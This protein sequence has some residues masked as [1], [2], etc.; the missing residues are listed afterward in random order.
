M[1]SIFFRN[2]DQA[3]FP[4]VA[5]AILL[6]IVCVFQEANFSIT[7]KANGQYAFVMLYNIVYG[8]TWYVTPHS[9]VTRANVQQGTNSM[10]RT[11]RNLSTTRKKQGHGSSNN[12]VRQHSYEPVYPT[13]TNR[14]PLPLA[15]SGTVS[16]L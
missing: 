4:G 14:L 10:A 16:R 13:Y 11:S 5:M 3:L 2:A 7:T 15:C 8:F 9:L 12:E 1:Q 6:A